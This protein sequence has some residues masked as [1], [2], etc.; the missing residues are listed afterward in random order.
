LVDYL[1]TLPQVDK[2]HIALNGYSRDGKMALIAAGLDTRIAAV[3]PG[4]TNVGGVTPWRF[5]Q[6]AWLWREHQKHDEKLPHL[7]RSPTEIFLRARG[8]S[9]GRRQF[10]CGASRSTPARIGLLLRRGSLAKFWSVPATLRA[11]AR[12]ERDRLA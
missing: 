11:S 4:S 8:S 10:A 5:G 9:A 3:I 6:G 1:Y 12:P 7:V 2:Q